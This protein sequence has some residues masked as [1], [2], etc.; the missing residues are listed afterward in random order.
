MNG[1]FTRQL[2]KIFKPKIVGVGVPVIIENDKKEILLEKRD[3]NFVYPF[4]W[5]LPGGIVEYGETPDETAKREVKEE[6]GVD[7]EI[8]KEAKKAYTFLPNKKC[9]IQSI[10]IVYY[11]RIKKGVPKPVSETKEVKWFNSKQIKEMDLAY[12]HKEILK[13]EGL[14]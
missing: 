8:L 1:F 11:A 14:I 6:I 12:N 4:Y 9:S 5:A 13:G 3:G 10:G 2:I 7:I